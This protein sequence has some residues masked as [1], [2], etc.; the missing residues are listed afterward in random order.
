MNL[1]EVFINNLKFYRKQKGL[2]QNELTLALDKSYNYINSIEQ[3]KMMPSFEAIEQICNV[4]EIKA[5]QL[6]DE[7]ASPDNI[8]T[9]DKENYINKLSEK[10]FEKLKTLIKTEIRNTIK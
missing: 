4:L 8:K 9:F 1:K 5:V 10:L 3:G 7:N 6:F 2:T